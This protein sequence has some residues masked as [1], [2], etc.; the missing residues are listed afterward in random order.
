MAKVVLVDDEMTLLQIVGELLRSDGHQVVPF[1][2][3][4]AAVDSL[5][6]VIPD[7]IIAN[8]R[9][10]KSRN[11]AVNVLQKA[12]TLQ[13]PALVIMITPSGSMESA[14]E[15]IRRGAYDYLAKPFTLDELK[16]R[17]QRALSYQSALRENLALRK[18]LGSKSQFRGIIGASPKM[19]EILRLIERVAEGESSILISGPSGTGKE[20][21]ARSIHLNSRRRLAPFVSVRCR[22]ISENLLEMELFGQKKVPFSGHPEEQIGLVREADGGTLFLDDFESLS[23]PL[24]T[25]LLQVLIEH[26]VLTPGDSEPNGVDVRML[27]ATHELLEPKLADGN[28]LREFHRLLSDIQVV[29]P[30]LR[31]RTEDIPLL[32]SHFLEGKLHPRSGQ[33]FSISRSAVDTCSSYGWPGNVAELESAIEH[34]C[35]LSQDSTISN[36]D[37][38]RSVQQ[39]GPPPTTPLRVDVQSAHLDALAPRHARPSFPVSMVDVRRSDLSPSG[40]ELVPLK[41]FLRDQEL[42][43]LHRTLAQVG[44][45]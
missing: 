33:P 8:L 3:G 39:L 13:P 18:Q 23:V 10:D 28:L 21:I 35:I 37:L 4:T 22:M 14:L 31:E 16:L 36:A 7:L 15:A 20:L 42:S 45:S 26:R 44:G 40:A 6:T 25:R 17:V 34:A 30:P 27:A 29:V 32:I 43:Y 24:Q 12:R 2:Q 19:Q 5:S 9:P 41:K 11:V 1:T 38:P